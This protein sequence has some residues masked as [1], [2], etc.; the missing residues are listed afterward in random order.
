M[1]SNATPGPAVLGEARIP[2]QRECRL[3]EQVQQRRRLVELRVDSRRARSSI[4]SAGLGT[5]SGSFDISLL[6]KNAFDDDTNVSQTWN[7][8]GPAFPRWWGV[9]FSGKL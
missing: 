6:L 2:Y 8:Y 3:A 7:S 5:R 4:S 9:V 1:P